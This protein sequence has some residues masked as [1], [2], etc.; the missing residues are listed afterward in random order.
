MGTAANYGSKLRRIIGWPF[1]LLYG[2]ILRLRHALYDA[3]ILSSTRP[4]MPTIVVGNIALGGTGKTPH[5]ELVLRTLG[6]GPWATLSRGYGR[7]GTDFL[8]VT[9][10]ENAERVGDEPLQVKAHF[11]HVHVFVGADRVKALAHITRTAPEVTAVVL[12]DALQHRPLCAGL[13]IVLTTWSKPW[14]DDALLPAGELR[15]L[16][17][18]ARLADV[19]VVTKSPLAPGPDVVEAWRERLGLREEQTLFFSGLVYDRPIG[20][21]PSLT[22]VPTGPDAGAIL[23]TG[24]A[25]PAPLLDHTRKLWGE[26]KHVAFPDHHAFTLA[27][28]THLAGVFDTFARQRKTLVTTEKDAARLRS[29][30]MGSPLEKLPVAVIGVQAVILTEP[31]HFAS[32]LRTH[33]GPHQAHR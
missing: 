11:P 2:G 12:D 22:E 26:V 8:E 10:S 7:K 25:D 24:I 27:D 30:I 6:N 9:G 15:D 29:M 19:V 14:C 5:V 18:R 28:L 13:N 17:Y 16:P 4:T 20:L 3:G 31:E 23:F 21:C 33:V 32:I 1:A